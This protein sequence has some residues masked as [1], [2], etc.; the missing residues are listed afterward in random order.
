MHN[1]LRHIFLQALLFP[2][3]LLVLSCEKEQDKSNDTVIL[4]L[5]VQ[6]PD[7]QQTK[8]TVAADDS[9]NEN[10]L[11]WIDVFLFSGDGGS[12][13]EVYRT[14][15]KS[16]TPT[17]DALDPAIY[18]VSV[19]I[20]SARL[21]AL[22]G[23]DDPGIGNS[24]TAKIAV[25]GNGDAVTDDGYYMAYP[26]A[27]TSSVQGIRESVATTNFDAWYAEN[28]SY[29]ICCGTGT[30]T[31]THTASPDEIK[32]TGTIPITRAYA[33]LDLELELPP[34]GQL[35]VAGRIYQANLSTMTIEMLNVVRKGYAGSDETHIRTCGS[36]D[37]VSTSDFPRALT[38]QGNP[39]VATHN[40]FYSYPRRF[41]DVPENK[42]VYRVK[43]DWKATDATVDDPVHT[44]YYTFPVVDE[45]NVSVLYAN[46]YYHT[47]AGIHTLGS[48]NPAAPE[49]LEGSWSILPWGTAPVYG[50]FNDYEYLIGQPTWINMHGLTTGTAHYKS[51]SSLTRWTVTSVRMY[52]VDRDGSGNDDGR[53]IYTDTTDSSVLSNYTLTHNSD[54]NTI[55]LNHPL[56]GMYFRQEISVVLENANGLSETI[57]F[58]Q[59]PP[60]EVRSS[61]YQGTAANFFIDGLA[62]GQGAGLGSSSSDAYSYCRPPSKVSPDTQLRYN[63]RFIVSSFST[64]N[65]TYVYGNPSASP[66]VRH[67]YIIGDPRV[68][69]TKFTTSQF[70][71]TAAQTGDYASYQWDKTTEL[72]KI[73]ITDR[74]ESSAD[75]IAPEFICCSGLATSFPQTLDKQEMRAAM[76]QESGYPAGRWR[77]MTESEFKFLADLQ[78]N[79]KIPTFF[80]QHASLGYWTAQNTC[81]RFT[82]A[83]T[84][85]QVAVNASTEGYARFVYDTWYWGENPVPAAA[86]TYTPMP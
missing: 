11:S 69:Q 4:T 40:C 16:I 66:Q 7:V 18:T 63:L 25:V 70:N 31:L 49:E 36:G 71:R 8:A 28:L 43:I 72:D 68:S 24:R 42:M 62:I 3:V 77:L 58:E 65:N 73:L 76:Y 34:S 59:T 29:L 55:T 84:Y 47:E 44:G 50:T 12:G 23:T 19:P 48:P 15:Y 30:V 2:L 79:G 26:S 83:T 81:Y 39:L 32:A 51:S 5:Q 54:A 35:E 52:A 78:A 6:L 27:A 67:E 33:K 57:I 17:Q 80:V 14:P 61:G 46:H 9:R 22:F 41:S 56:T 74:R 53:D 10:V 21:V 13:T 45:E 60:I 85:V 20:S 82:S 38:A 37:F 1:T 75:W 64:A 86:T